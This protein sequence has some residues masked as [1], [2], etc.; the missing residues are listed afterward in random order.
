M[1]LSFILEL[2]IIAILGIFQLTSLPFIASVKPDV[3]LVV[4]LAMSVYDKSW[5]RRLAWLIVASAILKFLPGTDWRLALFAASSLFGMILVDYLPWK[6]FISFLIALAVSGYIVNF[7]LFGLQWN[8]VF[9]EVILDLVIG[10][11]IFGLAS[12]FYAKKE[13]H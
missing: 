1:F 6:R 9:R 4:L 7:R 12:V 3:V 13:I 11:I 10:S 8:A 2:L 5:T